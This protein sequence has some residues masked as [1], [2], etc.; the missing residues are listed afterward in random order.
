MDYANYSSFE[1]R[2][3]K[4]ENL[5]FIKLLIERDIKNYKY[6]INN[7]NII[8]YINRAENKHL[9]AEIEKYDITDSDLNQIQ[10]SILKDSK[11]NLEVEYLPTEDWEFDID[12]SI[13]KEIVIKIPNYE[14]LSNALA[15]FILLFPFAA[16]FLSYFLIILFR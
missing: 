1:Q 3:I 13:K 2:L 10:T 11:Y 7:E 14:M 16:L 9:H 5:S 15:L 12:P 8:D 6:N 4:N